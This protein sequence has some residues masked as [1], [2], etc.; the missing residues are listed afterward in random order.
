[1][2]AV[3]VP[4]KVTVNVGFTRSLLRMVRLADFPPVAVGVKVTLMVQ[5]EVVARLGPQGLLEIAKSPAFAPVSSM[6]LIVKGAVAGP[7]G[8][9][10]IVHGSNKA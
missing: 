9:Y 3:P 7:A 4:L 10:V 1:M 5:V 6:L 8:G 2:G